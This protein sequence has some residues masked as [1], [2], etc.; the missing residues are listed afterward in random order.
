MIKMLQCMYTANGVIHTVLIL[1]DMVCNNN[2]CTVHISG[3]D[4]CTVTAPQHTQY[5]KN[6]LPGRLPCYR[7]VPIRGATMLC[8]LWLVLCVFFV[9]SSVTTAKD[10]RQTPNVLASAT[11]LMHNVQAGGHVW[12][13]VYGLQQRLSTD[14]K[15]QQ[16]AT[17]TMFASEQDFNTA[18]STFISSG[19]QTT[20]S[21]KKCGGKA[22]GLKD[23]I[24]AAV[25]GITSAIEC[26]SIDPATSLC[27]AGNTITQGLKV[28]FWYAHS[29]GKW[30]LMTAYPSTHPQCS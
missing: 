14:A 17:K 27:N 21:L 23:C 2:Y 30:I 24:P 26:T 20:A 4:A 12:N 6:Q 22:R 25:L 28:A 15:H 1:N 8:S 7:Y 3:T 19:F 16:D 5:K 10:C 18:W 11:S 9:A 13:H 29:K